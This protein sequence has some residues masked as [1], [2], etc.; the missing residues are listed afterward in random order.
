MNEKEKDEYIY[1]NGIAYASDQ[2]EKEQDKVEKKKSKADGYWF[3]GLQ[4][5]ICLFI[6]VMVLLLKAFGSKWYTVVQE[7]YKEN[8]NQSIL[9]EYDPGEVR[10]EIQQIFGEDEKKT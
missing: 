10:R 7:W 2:D 5:I 9:I 8:L 1:H 4:A 3:T 6:I